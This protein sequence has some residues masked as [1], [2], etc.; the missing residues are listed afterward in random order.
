MKRRGGIVLAL[1]TIVAAALASTAGAASTAAAQGQGLSCRSTLKIAM[2]AP[3]TG[4]ASN[5]QL[6]FEFSGEFDLREFRGQWRMRAWNLPLF[7]MG[8]G[9]VADVSACAYSAVAPESRVT[10]Q[11]TS[12]ART[13]RKKLSTT[14]KQESGHGSR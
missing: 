7:A 3:F 14:R 5:V 2:V 8:R 6:T 13:K 11:K 4:G 10:A 9:Q 12:C 1:A